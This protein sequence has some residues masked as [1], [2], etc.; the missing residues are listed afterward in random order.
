MAR[1]RRELAKRGNE[2]QEL[3]AKVEMTI[4][5]E[6][7][8]KKGQRRSL[9]HTGGRAGESKMGGIDWFIDNAQSEAFIH[10][11]LRE[12]WRKGGRQRHGGL[13]AV[14]VAVQDEVNPT[15]GVRRGRER[16]E[17][18]EARNDNEMVERKRDGVRQDKENKDK[19]GTGNP[20]NPPS[21]HL[22]CSHLYLYMQVLAGTGM[23]SPKI[24]HT[25]I[26]G[27]FQVNL[28]ARDWIRKNTHI[29]LDEVDT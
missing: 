3:F 5:K 20:S 2:T 19:V 1:G 14:S 21:T 28:Y 23:G 17:Y 29:C 10:P 27:V 6:E 8:P 11:R 4:A 25:E 24:T 26:C 18:D 9:S 16:R 22:T 13:E 15:W 7:E 12:R